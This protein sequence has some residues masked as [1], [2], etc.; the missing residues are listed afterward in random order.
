MESGGTLNEHQLHRLHQ[1]LKPFMLRRVKADVVSEMASKVEKV[2]RCP[3]SLRQRALYRAIRDKI[4]I[5]DLLQVRACVPPDT[6]L[7]SAPALRA[8]VVGG[9][10]PRGVICSGFSGR[11]PVGQEGAEPDEHRDPAAQG[12]GPEMAPRF[13]LYPAG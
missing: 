10:T 4:S 12:K 9:L 13:R 3:L 2:V 5:A 11:E 6:G 8:E 7:C 1:V